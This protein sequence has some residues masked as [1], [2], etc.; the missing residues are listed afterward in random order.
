MKRPVT[1]FTAQW[2]DLPLD[3][4]AGLAAGWAFDGLE[5]ACKSSHLDVNRAY[6]RSL[7]WDTPAAAFDSVL[8]QRD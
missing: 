2:A 3:E 6:V 1:L 7:L 8:T 4:V 5:I